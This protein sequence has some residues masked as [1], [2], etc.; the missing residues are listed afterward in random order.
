MLG[1]SPKHFDAQTPLAS[2]GVDSLM[3]VELKNRVETGLGL[4]LPIAALLRSPKVGEL[5]DELLAQAAKAIENWTSLPTGH[6]PLHETAEAG[7]VSGKEL[8]AAVAVQPTGQPR[9]KADGRAPAAAEAGRAGIQVPRLTIAPEPAPPY[10]IPLSA[11]QAALWLQHQ[12][13]PGSVYSPA[14]TVRIRAAVDPDRLRRAFRVIAGRHPALRTTFAAVNGVP[15]Q[16]VSAEAEPFVLVEDVSGLSEAEFRQRL[17]QEANHV[18]DLEAGPLWRVCL[19]RR[20]PDDHVLM[21][22]AHHI[23]MDLWSLALVTSEFSALYNDPT[24]AE[25][26]PRPAATYGDY[27]RWQRSLLHSPA[28]ERMWDYWRAQLAGALPV[29]ELPTDRPR[30]PVQTF[31]G[32]IVSASFSPELTAGIRGLARRLGVTPYVVLLA[33]FQALLHRYTGQE[34]LIVGTTT[35]GRTHAELAD[36]VGYFVNPAPIRTVFAD[37]L[38]FAGLARQ[39]HEAVLGALANQDFPFP[40]IVER[41]RPPR[42]PA[43]PPIFQVM[44]TLQRSHLLHEAGLSQLA[45]SRAGVSVDLGGLPMETVTLA[46]RMS[47]FDLTLQV[48][49]SEAALGAAVEFNLDLFDP[50]TA[51]RLLGHY[52]T[53]LQSAVADA[54]RPVAA[55]PML[56]AEEAGRLAAW[57]AGPTV[58]LAHRCIHH[59]FEAQA[60]RTPDATALY[61]DP[62]G[63]RPPVVLTYR[64]LDARANQL[65]HALRRRGIGVE[66][67]VALCAE[68]SPEMVIA[69]LGVLKAGAAYIPLD[70]AA[71]PARLAAILRDAAPAAC[72]V[73]GAEGHDLLA[74]EVGSL[75]EQLSP[76]HLD[77][78]TWWAGEP[79]ERPAVPVT[80]D[81][82]AYIIYTSGSTGEPKGVM[83]QHA[84]LV[85]LAQAQV[86][87][88]DVTPQDRVYQFAA[89]T[90]D[91]SLSEIFIAL[92]SGA[93]LH[94]ARRDVVLSPESLAA[95]LRA[96]RI[97]NITLPP[98][99]L[100]LLNPD[101]L[102]DLRTVI[103]AGEACTADLV[104]RWT[105][106]PPAAAFPSRR[107]LNAYGP[108]E[109]TIGPTY[110]VA[111]DGRGDPPAL[112]AWAPVPIGRP[113]HNIQTYILDRHLQPAAVGVPGELYIGGVGVA[114]GYV[115]R[116]DLTAERF[117]PD[118]FAGSREQGAGSGEQRAEGRSQRSEVR[119]QRS[120]V[121]GQ[122]SEVRSYGL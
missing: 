9:A 62:G 19:F 89:Y 80:G 25:R 7:P 40:T 58:P 3:A 22:H 113:I 23:V 90:F 8:P 71:P 104:A 81:N 120:E 63:G 16:R 12:L 91:A 42:D 32:S 87:G 54:D 95:A 102:P 73:Y 39:V 85:N 55:L 21:L 35:A 88:F 60:D 14:F 41:L 33:A 84:G 78:P 17:T 64:E 115:G 53:L 65:A 69:I 37:G 86:I 109:T 106:A 10:E 94:I 34:D 68:R 1:A 51:Q 97:T 6:Q 27:V 18:F 59:A 108:T 61:F 93:A 24:A 72:L 92:T 45:L 111:C 107:F 29:L 82:L 50:A 30:P 49:D 26:L 57:S 99:L 38:T 75:V 122:R 117:V 119:G 28:A 114:R 11:G 44:F 79:A 116:P 2:L 103:S 121:R 100:R 96:Q 98:T 46:D 48:A 4:Q 66:D 52:E 76:L 5:V 43:R 20:G 47:P 56:T 13:N 83:L 74:A 101:D 15:V 110:H 70:P 105:Q 36:V 112:P 67:R 31:R 118:P 77:D